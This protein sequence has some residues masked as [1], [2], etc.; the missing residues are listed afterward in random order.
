[1][2]HVLHA[3][4]QRIK[5]LQVLPSLTPGGGA[6]QSLVMIAPKLKER[7][8]DVEVAFLINRGDSLTAVL[9]DQG[10]RVHDLSGAKRRYPNW[11]L[12]IRQLI[13]RTRPDIVH[14]ALFD[15]DISCRIAAMV[16]P[17]SVVSTWASTTYDPLR[18][19]LEPD[20]RGWKMGAVRWADAFSSRASRGY[21]HAVT[22]GVAQDG[23]RA[24]HVSPDRVFVVERGR[25]L[26]RFRPPTSESRLRAL[27][28]M[29][30]PADNRVLITVARQVHPKGHIH[31]L[32]AF[33]RLA[34]TNPDLSLVMVGPKGSASEVIDEELARTTFRN[35]IIDLGMR[36]DVHALLPGA[37]LYV[38]PSVRE[39]AAGAL[40]EAMSAQIP[41]V[42]TRLA[43]LDGC[44]QEEEHVIFAE[45]ADSSDLARAISATLDD[46]QTA[47]RRAERAYRHV[48]SRYSLD[49][50][51]E[52]MVDMYRAIMNRA[53]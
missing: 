49:Q 52:G 10:I 18:K 35:R 32:R 11:A 4:Q 37:D 20:A 30:L 12:R 15:V 5:T 25:D 39:G 48:L 29:G 14:S 47:T 46:P 6:E 28:L 21:F 51:A 17:V 23:I 50:S 24:L 19:I 26:N 2:S 45:P 34:A 8:V 36:E 42:A 3:K 44:V 40:L 31:L 27:K 1:M 33:D 41:I 43:G 7:G 9:Q 22:E 16:E 53:R 13:H 38:L